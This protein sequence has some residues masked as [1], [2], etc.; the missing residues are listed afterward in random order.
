MSENNKEIQKTPVEKEA[1]DKAKVAKP[2]R[3]IPA[4]L[5]YV[6]IMVVGVLIGVLIVKQPW[7]NIVK[8][9]NKASTLFS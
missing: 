3:K 2:D 4:A 6:G 5:I 8:K 9:G 1:T 7:K